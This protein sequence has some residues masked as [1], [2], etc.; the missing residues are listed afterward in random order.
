MALSKLINAKLFPGDPNVFL[1]A[2]SLMGRIP[3]GTMKTP[4]DQGG[5]SQARA[6]KTESIKIE[7]IRNGTATPARGSL[8]QDD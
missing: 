5:K 3:I 4:L 2:K 7:S 8:G 6:A 1:K